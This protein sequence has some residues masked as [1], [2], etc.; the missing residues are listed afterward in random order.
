MEKKKSTKEFKMR[1]ERY[2]YG[3]IEV[4]VCIIDV[5]KTSQKI[6]ESQAY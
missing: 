5:G 4:R 1:A 2:N 3:N 6:L